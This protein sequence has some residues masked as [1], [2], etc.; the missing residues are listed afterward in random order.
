MVLPKTITNETTV[1]ILLFIS[2]SVGK[3]FPGAKVIKK[4]NMLLKMNKNIL[5][6][7]NFLCIFAVK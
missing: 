5:D 3:S 2:L 6:L 7:S 1:M 4:V